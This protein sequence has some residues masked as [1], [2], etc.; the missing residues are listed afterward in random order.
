[1]KRREFMG[2]VAAAAT[3]WSLSAE[4]QQRPKWRVGFLTPSGLTT[5]NAQ[6]MTVFRSSLEA[7]LRDVADVE[8]VPGCA[9]NE[10]DR[11][12]LLSKQMVD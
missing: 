3:G 7:A 1:M 12:P 10:L 11:L 8:I 9:D 6:R 4:A 2:V 5:V